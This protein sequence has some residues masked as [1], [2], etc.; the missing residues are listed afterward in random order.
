M[1]RSETILC[2]RQDPHPLAVLTEAASKSITLLLL[3]CG[4]HRSHNTEQVQLGVDSAIHCCKSH[5]V[6]HL[7]GGGIVFELR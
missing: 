3:S 4:L 7:L 5:A 1:V 2:P 6:Q